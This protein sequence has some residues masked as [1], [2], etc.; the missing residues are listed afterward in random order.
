MLLTDLN[1]NKEIPL[2]DN[3]YFASTTPMLSFSRPDPTPPS[4]P[5]YDIY[6][7]VRLQEYKTTLSRTTFST[8]R[9]WWDFGESD[10]NHIKKGDKEFPEGT[11]ILK[12]VFSSQNP[13]LSQFKEFYALN[14]EQENH[15]SLL[16]IEVVQ[17]EQGNVTGWRSDDEGK[18]QTVSSTQ[19]SWTQ[20]LVMSHWLDQNQRTP[21]IEDV[22]YMDQFYPHR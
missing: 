16:R 5:Q 7:G 2:T 8:S 12:Q 19:S 9:G 4:G 20:F 17:D 21:H 13:S 22:N 1:K 11:L 18:I 14:R 3:F 10:Q 15:Q 6:Q